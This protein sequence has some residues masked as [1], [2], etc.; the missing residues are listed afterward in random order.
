LPIVAPFRLSGHIEFED[1]HALE[2]SREVRERAVLLTPAGRAEIGP[3]NSFTIEGVTPG[4]HSVVV[5]LGDTFV[6]SVTLGAVQSERMID[7]RNGG[8]E[9]QLTVL[10]SANWAAISGTVSDSQ[11][12]ASGGFVELRFNGGGSTEATVDSTGH[13]VFPHVYP[14]TYRLIAGDERVRYGGADLL[15]D[16]KDFVVTVTVHAGDKITQ[17]LKPIPPD[18]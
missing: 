11:S 15:D 6:K 5:Q 10:V 8:G 1:D 17:E 2:A 4:R 9:A 18:K 12:P 16:Y 7:V 3:D 14:G 13:F